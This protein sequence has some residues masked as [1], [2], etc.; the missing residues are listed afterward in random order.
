MARID[1]LHPREAARFSVQAP[2]EAG[3]TIFETGGETFLQIVTYGSATR[4]MKGVV[5]QTIQFGPEGIAALRSLLS[6]LP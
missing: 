4:E 1:A 3:Y 2:V 5:S 6:R